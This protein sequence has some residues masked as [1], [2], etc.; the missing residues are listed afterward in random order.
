MRMYMKICI[1]CGLYITGSNVCVKFLL[2]KGLIR[3]K[4]TITQA[5]IAVFVCMFEDVNGKVKKMSKC[6]GVFTY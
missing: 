5:E 6:N 3:R 2:S 1:I 4:T